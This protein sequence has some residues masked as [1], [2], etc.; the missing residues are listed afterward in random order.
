[1]EIESIVMPLI[2]AVAT[3]F[4]AKP[5]EVRTQWIQWWRDIRGIEE[6]PTGD[7]DPAGSDESRPDS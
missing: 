4:L 6:S 5:A 3:G 1:M 7:V 2:I